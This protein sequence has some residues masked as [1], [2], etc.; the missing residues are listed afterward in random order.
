MSPPIYINDVQDELSERAFSERRN[1]SVR[2]NVVSDK[3]SL[4]NKF[5]VFIP[6]SLLA[7]L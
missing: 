6:L 7:L 1:R 5:K 2:R 3:C 4:I